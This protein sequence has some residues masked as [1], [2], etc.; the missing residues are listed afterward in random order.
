MSGSGGYKHRAHRKARKR[1]QTILKSRENI[2]RVRA[3]FEGRGQAWD[4]A[5]NPQQLAALNH[6]ARHEIQ[7]PKSA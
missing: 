7:K 3:Q 6:A 5:N 1:G 4:P 2:A